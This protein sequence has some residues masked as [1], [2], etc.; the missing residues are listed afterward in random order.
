M[1]VDYFRKKSPAFKALAKASRHRSLEVKFQIS[2]KLMPVPRRN[3]DNNQVRLPAAT[4]S[5]LPPRLV[6][7]SKIDEAEETSSFGSGSPH[8]PEN[9][10]D[11]NIDE[12]WST[13]SSNSVTPRLE[14]QQQPEELTKQLAGRPVFKLTKSAPNILSNLGPGPV[15]TMP[16]PIMLHKSSQ[17]SVVSFDR[18]DLLSVHGHRYDFYVT[19]ITQFTLKRNSAMSIND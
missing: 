10:D 12:Q 11:L 2:P 4:E 3:S 19:H 5:I 15:E 8:S 18:S 16:E 14:A 13:S 7:D 17:M 6:S 1:W 9:K